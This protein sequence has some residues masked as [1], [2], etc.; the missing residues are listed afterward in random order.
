MRG[1][2]G[3]GHSP[4]A[5][6]KAEKAHLFCLFPLIQYPALPT[7]LSSIPSILLV[8]YLAPGPQGLQKLRPPQQKL[9]RSVPSS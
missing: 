8:Q 4:T 2:R 9:Q 3:P 6:K 7:Q 5:G 1:S